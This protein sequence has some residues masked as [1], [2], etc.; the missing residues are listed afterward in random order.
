MYNLAPIAEQIANLRSLIRRTRRRMR[1]NTIDPV[2]GSRIII[3]ATATL[4]SLTKTYEEYAERNAVN[5]SIR[6]TIK[7]LNLFQFDR[8]LLPLEPDPQP[9][10]TTQSP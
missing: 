5:A 8:S 6:K 10:S 9:T 3:R 1:N 4:L 7:E 2:K